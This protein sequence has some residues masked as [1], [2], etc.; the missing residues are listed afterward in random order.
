MESL[1]WCGIIV[2][3]GINEGGESGPY[4]QSDRKE[5]YRKYAE[6]LIDSGNAYYAFDTPEE[7][8]ALRL[9]YETEGKTFIYNSGVRDKLK[10]SISLDAVEWNA[11]A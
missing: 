9:Q 5:I 11:K 2:D 6:R 7:L 8:E 1:K 4:R 10:N 3:E